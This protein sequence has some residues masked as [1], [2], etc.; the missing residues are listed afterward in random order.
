TSNIQT[1]DASGSV[2]S[3]RAGVRRNL[4]EDLYIRAAAYSGFRPETLNELFRNFRIGNDFTA[5]NS[6]LAP[7]KLYGV[8]AGLGDDRGALTWAVT[9]FWNKIDDAVTLVTLGVGPGTF[10]IVGALPAGGRYMQRQNVGHIGAFGLEGEA[11]WALNDML[12][13]R[14]GFN[15]TDAHV[16]GGTQAPALTGKRPA[17]TPRWSITGGVVASPAS[18]VTLEGYVRYES[19]RWSDDLNTL[20]VNQVTVVDTRVNFHVLPK[21]D[22]YVGV[23]NIFD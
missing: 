5:A 12:S 14:G 6:G 19:L 15:V 9:G 22:V 23:D 20:P 4:N 1:P 13:L 18:W 21:A 10:P 11:Q 17:Q 16:H 2:P 3:A 7:E 8:E